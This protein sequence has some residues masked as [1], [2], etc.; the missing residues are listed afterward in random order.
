MTGGLTFDHQQ[1][2]ID[3]KLSFMSHNAQ[4]FHGINCLK[5]ENGLAMKETQCVSVCSIKF[6]AVSTAS[7]NKAQ[8]IL[9]RDM[10][11]V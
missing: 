4:D 10:T 8:W 5:S 3:P 11:P 9:L 2:F 1:I 7:L 6:C